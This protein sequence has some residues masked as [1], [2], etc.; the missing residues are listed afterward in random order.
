MGIPDEEDALKCKKDI[1]AALQE[2][3]RNKNADM[4][5]GGAADKR[6]ICELILELCLWIHAEPERGYLDPGKV[7]DLYKLN[8]RLASFVAIRQAFHNLREGDAGQNH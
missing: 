8:R 5:T 1:S 2:W 3:C 4:E 6:R 7:E